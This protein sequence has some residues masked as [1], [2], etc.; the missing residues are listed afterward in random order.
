MATRKDEFDPPE[1]VLAAVVNDIVKPVL[2][3]VAR[4]IGVVCLGSVTVCV[5]EERRWKLSIRGSD[6]I[7]DRVD[8][9]TEIRL[10][11]R[12]TFRENRVLFSIDTQHADVWRESGFSGVWLHGDVIANDGTL[13]CRI[14]HKTICYGQGWHHW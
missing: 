10:R 11:F 9:N 8:E 13:E 5:R 3:Q 14:R 4:E 1:I 7:V 6:T 12:R 2:A